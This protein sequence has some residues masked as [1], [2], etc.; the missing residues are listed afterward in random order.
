MYSFVAQA[1]AMEDYNNG[2]EFYKR[3][4]YT[5]AIASF[6]SAEKNGMESASLYYNLGSAYFK[7]KQYSASKHYY[8]LVKQYSDKRALAEFNL[9]MIALEQ[10]EYEEALTHFRYA[11]SNSSDN[12]IADAAKQT[13]ASLTGTVKRWSAYAAASFGYDDNI[14]VT[15]DNVA[16]GLDDT[17]YN[18]YA[19]TDLL[20]LGKRKSGWLLNAAFFT[21]DYSDSDSFDQDFYTVGL[22]NE[23][24][25]SS[26]NTTTQLKYGRSY[27]GG[28]DF[29]RFYKLDILGVRPLP[30]NARII[31]QYRFDELFSE[32]SNYDYLEGWRQRA[33]IRYSRNTTSSNLQIY[34]EGELNNGGELVTSLYSY[35]YSP[36]R[37]TL[38]TRYTHK[39]SEKW[40]LT[41]D[42]AYR[43]SVFP[44]S[45]TLDRD[46]TRWT[47][48]LLLEYRIDPTFVLKSDVK[49]IQNDSSVDVYTY[50][51]TLITLGMSK[52]F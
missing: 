35:E 17:F 26:W 39:Y 38:G 25:T 20:I 33:Q 15:P 48:D 44:A 42:L 40:H 21:I 45:S 47:I 9:G 6:K 14:N 18:I 52:L 46:D 1:S 16:L 28:D 41:G 19:S 36:T 37:H 34:Y 11:E 43:T 10:N 51:K 22:R 31:L 30:G 4:E 2:I 27:F 24:Q 7:I 12:R 23:H 8:T 29:Q 5:S 32:N 3:G 49:Y 13:I 50:D